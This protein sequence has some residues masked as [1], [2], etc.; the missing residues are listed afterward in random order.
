[1]FNFS[2]GRVTVE[3]HDLLSIFSIMAV[4]YAFAAIGYVIWHKRR[5]SFNAEVAK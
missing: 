1:M 2:F 5:Q 4:I 3:A